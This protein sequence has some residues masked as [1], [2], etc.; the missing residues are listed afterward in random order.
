MARVVV[1]A[2]AGFADGFR[3]A[4]PA[5]HV[6]RPGPEAA[7]AARALA[8]EGDVGVLLITADLWTSLDD[9]LRGSLERLPRPIVQPIPA[10]TMTDVTTRRQLLGEMLQR[11]IG[12]RV[13][14][15]GTREP[16][17]PAGGGRR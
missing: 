8:G 7:Q 14:L 9:R 5:T 6:A 11:A 17:G 15:S 10:G 2:S 13:E 4:G 12:Y 1:L 3:L 16:G